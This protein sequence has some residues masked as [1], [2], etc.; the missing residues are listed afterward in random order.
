MACTI[1]I[2]SVVGTV[3]TPVSSP[4][5]IVVTGTA[6]GCATG[7]IKV[8]VDCGMSDI[9]CRMSDVGRSHLSSTI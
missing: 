3:P 8:T 9:G 1:T 7:L 4:T 2:T 6:S 5:G